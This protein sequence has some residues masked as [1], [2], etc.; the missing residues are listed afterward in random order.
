MAKG[1]IKNEHVKETVRI[2]KIKEIV[3]ETETEFRKHW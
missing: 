3:S 2:E 1:I